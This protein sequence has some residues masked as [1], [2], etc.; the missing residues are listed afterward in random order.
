M[1]MTQGGRTGRGARKDAWWATPLARTRLGLRNWRGNRRSSCGSESRLRRGC[2]VGTW[3]YGRPSPPTGDAARRLGGGTRTFARWRR[4]TPAWQ[5][6]A[7][8][9][10]RRRRRSWIG[11]KLE[12]SVERPWWRVN[13]QLPRVTMEEPIDRARRNGDSVWLGAFGFVNK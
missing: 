9:A 12:V 4:G 5:S 3:S 6:E 13:L 1:T 8:T 7:E 10:M 2:Q 11:R